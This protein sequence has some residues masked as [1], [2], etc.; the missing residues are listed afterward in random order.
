M[1][2]KTGMQLSP[3]V[4]TGY[5]HHP[6]FLRHSSLFLTAVSIKSAGCYGAGESVLFWSAFNNFLLLDKFTNMLTIIYNIESSEV[7]C[8]DNITK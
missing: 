6:N 1:E 4:T 5:I 2:K 8:H 3:V 7:H